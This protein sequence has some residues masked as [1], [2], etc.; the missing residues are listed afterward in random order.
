MKRL[1][2]FFIAIIILAAVF[3]I[4][5][6]NKNKLDMKQAI[7]E[8]AI[9]QVPVRVDTVTARV[10]GPVYTFPGILEPGQQLMVMSQAQGEVVRVLASFGD[11]VR[12]GQTV[13]KVDDELLLANMEVAAAS[14]EKA[15]KDLERF[16]KMIKQ[17]G[18][19]R[20]QLEQ[21]R[22]N[23]KNSRSKMI[24]LRK[25]IDL[26]SIEA[27]F[28]GYINQMFTKKGA[29]LGP[30]T[31]VFEIVD[32]DF[33]KITLNLSEAEIMDVSEKMHVIIQ[34][35]VVDTVQLTGTVHAMARSTNMAQQFAV[36]IHV[37][38][39][40]P[41][42]IKGGMMAVVQLHK[43]DNEPSLTLRRALI[44]EE[45]GKAYVYIVKDKTAIKTA[46]EYTAGNDDFVKIEKGLSRGD[47]VVSSGMEQLKDKTRVKIIR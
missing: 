13:V 41:D 2:T 22:L 11:I 14:Y 39:P 5:W 33:F 45:G 7:S 32:T 25:R 31:P 42:L 23:E 26:S 12:K 20:D 34:P 19:T 27:P 18:V 35:K 17:D 43:A 44:R 38:N 15:S 47:L 9:E 4:L 30:G 40:Y 8:A 21:M 1:I 46:L 10:L 37:E 16:E 6:L 3:F 24:S 36:E 29:L 28:T